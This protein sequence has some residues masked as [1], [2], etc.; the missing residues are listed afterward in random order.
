MKVGKKRRIG[1]VVSDKCSKTVTVLVKRVKK[2]P[3]IEKRIRTVKKYKAHD[4]KDE[5]R[6]GFVVEIEE[7]RPISK[8][9]RWRVANIL[10]KVTE[11]KIELKDETG[12]LKPKEKVKEV[13]EVEEEKEVKKEVKND[14]GS[15]NT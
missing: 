1:I 14:S 4:E 9:K 11:E 6:V 12:V 3:M 15:I 5:C 7:C 2:H 8:T 13:K 10:Q